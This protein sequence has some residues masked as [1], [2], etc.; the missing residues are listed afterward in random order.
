MSELREQFLQD[1]VTFTENL[2]A[3]IASWTDRRPDESQLDR[4]FRLA[5]SLKSEAEYLAVEGVGEAA[6]DLE[7]ILQAVRD[8]RTTWN[9][10]TA[11]RLSERVETLSSF[12]AITEDRSEPTITPE[13]DGAP[14]RQLVFTDLERTLLREAYGRGER[15]YR[16]LVSIDPE[17]PMKFPRAYLVA[18]NLEL[19]V[20]VIRIDPPMD[21]DETRD[22]GYVDFCVTTTLEEAA[23]RELI[24]VDEVDSVRVS[25]LDFGDFLSIP[26]ARRLALRDV[27][28]PGFRLKAAQVEHL[29]RLS[30]MMREALQEM[31]DAP[32]Q[33]SDAVEQ[34]ADFV[35]DLVTVKTGD[36]ASTYAQYARETARKSGKNVEVSV[37]VDASTL[38]RETVSV[39]NKVVGQ[40]V[41]NAVVHGIE[42]PDERLAG[43]KAEPGR[44]NVGIH[45]D[46]SFLKGQVADDGR[47]IPGE[48][49]RS[50]AKELGISPIQKLIDIIST[51]GFTTKDDA[52]LSAGRGVGLDVVKRTIEEAGGSFD[53][54]QTEG[55]GCRFTFELP[56]K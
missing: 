21:G 37:D 5:H 27:E 13:V 30:R 33:L 54:Y 24:E 41:S 44:L 12:F 16:V 18:N 9:R 26:S 43:G 1:G 4:A 15:A 53:L 34:L 55:E 35:A 39:L 52:D 17:S 42:S 38:P 7:S 47:G 31:P 36:L 11:S 29:R 2:G 19:S 46:G 48:S 8:Q 40:L 56:L 45:V 51:P 28:I 22:Y 10:D 14:A 23:L 49:I 3:L 50:R 6:H 32:V 20:N 25:S